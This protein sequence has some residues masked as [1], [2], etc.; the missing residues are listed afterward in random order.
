M[1]T[2]SSNVVAIIG[3]PNVGKSTLFNRLI[4]KREAIVADVSGIT[5][6]RH[7][8]T[9]IWNGKTFTVID[10][11]GYVPQSEDIFE[12]AIAEQVEIAMQEAEILLFVVDA[13]EGL[14]PLDE[15]FADIVRKQKRKVLLVA[16]KVDNYHLQAHAAEFYALNLTDEI[17]N[18]SAISGSGTGELLDRITQLLPKEHTQVPEENTPR[19][20]F[21]GRPNVGKSSLVNTLLG[22]NRS[23]VTPIAGTT[24]DSIDTHYTAF[25]YD[26][27]LVDTAGLRKRAKVKEN[28][29]FYSTVRTIKAIQE[30]DVAVLVLDA[31]QGLEAQDLHILDLIDKNRK[32][33][34][35]AVNKWD[36]YPEKN[37]NTHIHYTKHIEQKILPLSHIPI[38]YTSAV[39]KQRVL[40]ILETA[41]HVYH[42]QRKHI[43]THELNEFLQEITEHYPPPSIKGKSIK[44]KYVTQVNDAK[45][46]TFLFFCNLPQYIQEPYKRYIQNKLHERYGFVGC[47]MVLAFKKK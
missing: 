9:V 29:E 42:E 40:K 31:T 5:R 12:K 47:S 45:N 38:L 21:V 14:T 32:G 25:G 33:K 20:A 2:K 24:R 35:I 26:V 4:E 36:L 39:T 30:C 23:I 11:G 19:I 37:A 44:I 6:D 46:P 22:E 15:L 43:P 28:I 7:Y 13:R 8:G 3:R 10:T 1:P 41:V 27:I 34:V 16:N 17:F 18:I